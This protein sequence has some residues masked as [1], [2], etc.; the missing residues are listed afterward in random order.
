MIRRYFLI[1]IAL[2]LAFSCNKESG[3]QSNYEDVS[4]R[5]SAND[6]AAWVFEK[7]GPDIPGTPYWV[8]DGALCIRTHAGTF[9]RPKL[10]TPQKTFT[11]GV[12]TWK[13]FIPEVTEGDQTSFGSW[14]Y[15]DDQHEIDFE[16]GWG[17]AS[18]RAKT[19]AGSNQLVAHMTNQAYPK[20][21]N[22]AAVDAGQWHIFQ[23]KLD[24]KT[25]KLDGKKKSCYY[26]SWVID[27]EVVAE[28]QLEFGPEVGFYIF[29]SV[30]NLKFIGD[31][32]AAQDNIG[33]YE[34]MTFEG[35]VKKQ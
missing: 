18:P 22:Y 20:T 6:M 19:K 1:V 28:K 35:K 9:E 8:E 14:I 4:L 17:V 2:I 15:C 24:L 10:H 30:E 31:T 3:D 33:K 34:W 7:Q 13:A 11:S 27:G 26:C 32:P 12:Y 23:I 25:I 16:V 29:V 21:V 5:F